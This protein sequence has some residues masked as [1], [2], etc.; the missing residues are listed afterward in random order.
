MRILCYFTCTGSH[1]IKFTSP[2]CCTQISCYISFLFNS[3]ALNMCCNQ[4]L[5]AKSP[6]NIDGT[7]DMMR[8]IPHRS[9]S[10][11]LIFSSL[12]WHLLAYKI[13]WRKR[14]APSA[15]FRA[16]EKRTECGQSLVCVCCVY[17]ILYFEKHKGDLCGCWVDAT[18]CS[19][20][21]NFSVFHPCATSCVHFA[22]FRRIYVRLCMVYMVSA[23]V[24]SQMSEHFI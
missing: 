20:L 18:T 5:I 13:E 4:L 8:C 14:W 1:G 24:L 19:I 15:T 17:A 23:R 12:F 6:K 16:E 11:L 9:F 3:M 10:Y 2:C 22:G 7:Q 21:C